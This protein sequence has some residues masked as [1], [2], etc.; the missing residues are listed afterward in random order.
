MTIPD[1]LPGDLR[2][3]FGEGLQ[4]EKAIREQHAS[5]TT[6]IVPEPP[7]AVRSR[8]SD[9][10][11]EAEAKAADMGLIAPIAGHVRDGELHHQILVDPAPAG[12]AEE[13]GAAMCRY[14]PIEAG[15]GLRAMAA[16]EA[17]L[18][19]RGIMNSG[20]ILPDPPGRAA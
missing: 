10:V 7:D 9:C 2:A 16:I 15:S 20:R 4:T 1:G 12:E 19:P 18:D 5:R 11:A 6:W 3:R 8:L 14:P 17:A 13:A